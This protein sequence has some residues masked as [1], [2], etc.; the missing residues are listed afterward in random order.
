MEGLNAAALIN[1]TGF[2]VGT[3][4]YVLIAVMVIRHRGGSPLFS[5]V[6]RLLL[7]T[8]ALGLLWN[9]GELFLFVQRDL[10]FA[11][12]PPLITALSYSALGFLPSVVVHS[13]ETD[14]SSHWP[15]YPAYALSSAAAVLHIYF[16]VY[17]GTAP[18]QGGLMLMTI[19]AAAM[20]VGLLVLSF[21]Q[22][23]EKKLIWAGALLIFAASALHLGGGR[24][25]NS[26][27]IEL[28][29]HQSSLPLAL[30]ILYQNYKFGFGDLFLK[31]ALSL[32]LLTALAF[33]L[34]VF[35]ANPLLRF[36][37]THDRNDVQAISL[38]I[39]LWVA[40]ALVYPLLHK[41]AGW[42]VDKVV[43]KRADYAKLQLDLARDF[44]VTDTPRAIL[45]EMSSK[46]ASVL[47]AARSGWREIEASAAERDFN[48]VSISG[49]ETKIH[50][51]TAEPPFYE[52]WMG[53]FQG[54]RRLLSDETAMLEAA[55]YSA[56]RR[57]DALRVLHERCEQEIREE[58]FS[59]LAAEAKLTA[60][61]SQIN[62]H[63]LFNA[64]TTI[65]YLIRTEPDKAGQT[66]L[67]LTRLLRSVLSE[68]VEFWK[69]EDEM[70][71][72][73]NYLVIER[74]RFEE[75]L[76]VEIDIPE[77]IM[78]LSV[79]SLILQPL[80]ENAIKHAVSENVAG[81]TIRIAARKVLVEGRGVVELTVEDSGPRDASS[82]SYKP[83]GIGLKNVR[84][85]IESCYPDGGHFTIEP[86][87]GGTL[88]SIEIPQSEEFVHASAVR[89]AVQFSYEQDQIDHRR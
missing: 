13:A 59:K 47:T 80:V 22:K 1:L 89:A 58:E 48:V 9:L 39:F 26:W 62:P 19:G 6:N 41:F 84:E 65:G 3:A 88:C 5:G 25:N 10:A 56:A 82:L 43:L 63:F 49:D 30:A 38:I 51:P 85:R 18:S 66:L 11:K 12:V 61:R 83:E 15:K 14:E 72:I 52:V 55:A 28:V 74:A 4:L 32:I 70:R 68:P 8:S 54:G 20:T 16:A 36:H 50:L 64:L 75:R 7:T 42:F 87:N 60:L 40:T 44:E 45:H 33:G 34:Y 2:A 24:E 27:L 73:E 57:M 35:V 46:L 29:G 37:E 53:E 86:K 78:G 31:R 81:G 79:P 76:G 67:Q 71:L 69:L 23:L 17:T 77:D 21:T